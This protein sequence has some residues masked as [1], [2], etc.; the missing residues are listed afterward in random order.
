[1]AWFGRKAR[2]ALC[3]LWKHR[4]DA[5]HV[6]AGATAVLV[7][8]AYWALR[9]TEDTL[10]LSERAWVGPVDAKIDAIP[11]E[12]KEVKATVTVRNTG[13]EPALDF[14]WDVKPIIATAT[15][16]T[17]EKLASE[18]VEVCFG[19]QPVRRAQ[20][21]YPSVGSGSGFE[22]SDTIPEELIDAG[23]VNG[24]YVI[25][26]SSRKAFKRASNDQIHWWSV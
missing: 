24:N 15:E 9:D 11:Q 5:N 13:R 10:E 21:L 25:C 18:H 2:G 14:T 20:V 16:L 3:F 1:M 23:V 7:V 22:F 12:G 6:L 8:I 17:Q 19:T 4:P 26:N